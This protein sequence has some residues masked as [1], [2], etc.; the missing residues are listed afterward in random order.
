MWSRD[1]GNFELLISA[2][3]VHHAIPSRCIGDVKMIPIDSQGAR[4]HRRLRSQV[5]WSQRL[6][7]WSHGLEQTQ[8]CASC[9]ACEWMVEDGAKARVE[10]YW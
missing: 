3:V 8:V 5:W 4:V 7:C 2:R 6:A 10:P 1:D 9:N